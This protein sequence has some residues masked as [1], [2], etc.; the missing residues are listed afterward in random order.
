MKKGTSSYARGFSSC[1]GQV[2]LAGQ[3]GAARLAAEESFFF[4]DGTQ[5]REL[6][7]R[8]ALLVAAHVAEVAVE[9]LIGVLASTRP[10]VVGE[11]VVDD[12]LLLG[13]LGRR[14]EVQEVVVV[15]PALVGLFAVRA[16]AFHG[17]DEEFALGGVSPAFDRDEVVVEV[18]ID[19]VDL[20]VLERAVNAGCGHVVQRD[21]LW[22]RE[23]H[24]RHD[25]AFGDQVGADPRRVHAFLRRR[26]DLFTDERGALSDIAFHDG[27]L[28]HG[29]S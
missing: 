25:I 20:A 4:R 12:Q 2:G 9:D 8:V 19:A 16:A 17:L 18:D 27:I 22:H 1:S 5:G 26:L 13:R 3:N 21:T 11:R 24:E 28:V 14:T 10:V 7:V 15:S 6:D 23:L 29:N